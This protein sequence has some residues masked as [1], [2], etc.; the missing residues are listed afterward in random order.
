MKLEIIIFIFIFAL[1]GIIFWRRIKKTM[2]REKTAQKVWQT[3]AGMKGLAEGKGKGKEDDADLVF[4]GQNQGFPFTLERFLREGKPVGAMKI[5]GRK[6]E[7]KRGDTTDV[8]TCMKLQ[9]PGLP[10]GLHVYKEKTG[11]KIAK[12]LGA[13]DI[14]VSEAEFDRAFMVK[15][16]E[17]E[18]VKRYLTPRRREVMKRYIQELSEVELREE[19][20]YLEREG[21]IG[22]LM[23][24][25]KLYTRLGEMAAALG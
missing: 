2:E 18:E 3:F 21:Q 20:L 19:G 15:G 24:L 25:E 9:L 14:I 12:A 22:D 11:S 8:Y 10:R 17:P 5:G 4:K 7:F 13:Q 23:E 1:V 16:D 6:V